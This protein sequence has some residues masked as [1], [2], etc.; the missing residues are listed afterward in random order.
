MTGGLRPAP[1]KPIADLTPENLKAV[2]ADMERGPGWYTSADLYRWYA[3][4]AREAELD[5]VS[6]KRFGMVLGELGYRRQI[7][8]VNG[9]NARC[10]FLSARAFRAEGDQ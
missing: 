6:P 8:R 3:A 2:L 4:M 7:R 5:P 10:W 9:S 1:P